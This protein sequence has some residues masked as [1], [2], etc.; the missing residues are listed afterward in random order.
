MSFIAQLY[1]AATLVGVVA[2]FDFFERRRPRNVID[3]RRDLALNVFAL[4]VVIVAGEGWK[5]LLVAGLGDLGLASAFSPAGLERLPGAVKIVLGIA[6]ADFCLYWV[7]R[8]MHR[9]ALWPAHV[10]HHSIA[11]LWWLSGARTSATH[12]LLFAVPQVL[13]AY[14]VFALSA[15]EAA[16]A[17][18]FGVVVN[19]WIHTNLWVDIGPL[20]WLLITPNYHRV[21]HGARGLSNNNLGFVFTVWDRMFGTFVDPDS[22]GKDFPLGFASTRKRLLRMVA[23]F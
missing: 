15:H 8:A 18:S 3:R 5:E 10:F 7:H 13:L 11:E 21:H 23:G 1:Q 16:A 20:Q 6:A 4:M 14:F 12:L 2:L 9:P 19:V 22:A 17:F